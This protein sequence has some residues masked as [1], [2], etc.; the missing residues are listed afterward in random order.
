M[1]DVFSNRFIKTLT[2]DKIMQ[3][4]SV[5]SL[6]SLEIAVTERLHKISSDGCYSTKLFGKDPNILTHMTLDGTEQVTQEECDC[7]GRMLPM[8]MM[9]VTYKDGRGLP[10]KNCTDCHKAFNGDGKRFLEAI[11]N[12]IKEL[13]ANQLD[14]CFNQGKKVA[15]KKRTAPDEMCLSYF[16]SE[17]E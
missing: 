5:P 1:S 14:A 3:M 7:C 4:E 12:R 9:Y 17:E 8:K 6:V 11:E 16:M 10:R 2:I 15:K 13:T